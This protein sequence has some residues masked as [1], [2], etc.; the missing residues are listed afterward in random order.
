MKLER[1][2]YQSRSKNLAILLKR[3]IACSLLPA[4]AS[5]FSKYFPGCL[6][7][8]GAGMDGCSARLSDTCRPCTC[9]VLIFKVTEAGFLW[10]EETEQKAKKVIRSQQYQPLLV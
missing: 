7:V 8:T 1:A 6:D 5:R 9:K 4:N 2:G 3:A 10:K